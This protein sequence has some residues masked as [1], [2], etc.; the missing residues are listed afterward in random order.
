[1]TEIVCKGCKETVAIVE[2]IKRETTEHIKKDIISAVESVGS[3]CNTEEIWV[4]DQILYKLNR[5]FGED[6]NG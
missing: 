4:V 6:K 5:I 3:I 1:M 2:E